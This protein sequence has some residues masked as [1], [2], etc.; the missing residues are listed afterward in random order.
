MGEM[1]F[2]VLAL[3]NEVKNTLVPWDMSRAAQHGQ[4]GH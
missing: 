4:P 3:C 1:R 2:P